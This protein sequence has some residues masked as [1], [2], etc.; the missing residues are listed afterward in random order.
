[1]D[2]L[3]PWGGGLAA[4]VL[5]GSI[6]TM[7]YT[8]TARVSEVEENVSLWLILAGVVGTA[9]IV[10]PVVSLCNGDFTSY[11]GLVPLALVMVYVVVI[12][13][14]AAAHASFAERE[15]S[16]GFLVMLAAQ[17]RLARVLL[18]LFYPLIIVYFLLPFAWVLLVIVFLMV[19]LSAFVR[20]IGKLV[21]GWRD[22]RSDSRTHHA[23]AKIEEN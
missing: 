9:V 20:W 7:A 11:G 18:H 17:G 23:T 21:L 1:M 6:G 5:W 4:L 22:H 12:L 2:D 19:P 10:L 14:G 8:K 3:I 13:A 15:F 16:D